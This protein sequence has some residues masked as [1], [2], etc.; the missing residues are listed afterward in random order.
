MSLYRLHTFLRHVF[1]PARL[2][3]DGR[4]IAIA[5]LVLAETVAALLV[6]VVGRPFSRFA[7]GI[8]VQSTQHATNFSAVVLVTKFARDGMRLVMERESRGINDDYHHTLSLIK[9]G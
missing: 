1:A 8:L 4:T 2:D 5:A 9:S 7:F 6:S 3:I